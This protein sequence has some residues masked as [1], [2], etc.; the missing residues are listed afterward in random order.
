VAP[1]AVLAAATLL[2]DI[3][4]SIIGGDR[5]IEAATLQGFDF[6]YR[7]EVPF[8]TDFT[9]E[10]L[11]I[12]DAAP[13]ALIW[14]GDGGRLIT[15]LTELDAAG[16]E[17]PL[18][19]CGQACYSRTWVD[20]AGALGEGVSVWLP[21]QP[22]EESDVSGELPRYLFFLGSTHPGAIP[23]ST[24]VSAWASALLF[25]EAVRRAVAEDTAD[26][27]P[28]SLTRATLFSA[29][30][31]ISSW[32]A[33]GLH[34]ESNPAAGVPS[35]CFVLMTLT[36]GVWQ[37]TFPERR[38]AFDCAEENLVSLTITSSFGTPDPTPQGEPEPTAEDEGGE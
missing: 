18:I 6:A 1:D 17:I 32:D 37:R 12:A 24:G 36:D 11:D 5:M 33:R 30:R 27:D 14:P 2:V 23:T 26:Y 22:I 34:G 13:Q 3:P 35:G 25:E 20:E 8:T 10:A 29:V 28:A 15:L 4:V 19:D 21:T 38:G 16:V 9:E 31:S 7:A